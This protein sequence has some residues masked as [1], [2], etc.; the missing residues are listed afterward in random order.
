MARFIKVPVVASD[1]V[2]D[3]IVN[4]EGLCTFNALSPNETEFLFKDGAITIE[5][6][7]SVGTGHTELANAVGV[8]FFNKVIDL[9]TK[10][11]TK[12][13]DTYELPQALGGSIVKFFINEAP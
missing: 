11:Y 7:N 13:I 9:D 5:Y 12:V 8:K 6:E 10:S 4:I 1:Y 3:R 2:G